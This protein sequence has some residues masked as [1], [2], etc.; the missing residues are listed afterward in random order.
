ML[1]Q[2][3]STY[4][5]LAGVNAA[6]AVLAAIGLD[7]GPSEGPGKTLPR[8]FAATAITLSLGWS[9]RLTLVWIAREKFAVRWLSGIDALAAAVLFGLL[10]VVFTGSSGFFPAARLP[11]C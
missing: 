6:V 8:W 11:P 10:I 2:V 9:I 3:F 5:F 7:Y 4:Y 1:A